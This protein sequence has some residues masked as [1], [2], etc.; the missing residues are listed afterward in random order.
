MRLTNQ[1][2]SGRGGFLKEIGGGWGGDLFY[3]KQMDQQLTTDV[4]SD[5]QEAEM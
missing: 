3:Y 5:F 2:R 4:H 1:T